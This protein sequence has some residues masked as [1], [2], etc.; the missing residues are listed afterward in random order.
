ML[1]QLGP[2]CPALGAPPAAAPA[3]WHGPASPTPAARRWESCPV[4]PPNPPPIVA[5]GH[6]QHT[7]THVHACNTQTHRRWSV[8]RPDHTLAAHARPRGQ[9]A[10]PMCGVITVVWSGTSGVPDLPVAPALVLFGPA[11]GV[12]LDMLSVEWEVLAHPAGRRPRKMAAEG[13][14]VRGRKTLRRSRDGFKQQTAHKPRTMGRRSEQLASVAEGCMEKRPRARLHGSDEAAP[15]R[16][17][18]LSA[19]PR[20]FQSRQSEST[21]LCL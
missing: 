17:L 13:R 6:T 10:N 2:S 7:Y 9:L 18:I 5:P 4:V 15:A 12:E 21:R 8:W 20:A 1:C 16:L 14:G 3:A 19:S 11:R